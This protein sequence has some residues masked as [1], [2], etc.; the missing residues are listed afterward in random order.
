MVWPFLRQA[1]WKSGRLGGVREGWGWGGCEGE[2]R[3]NFHFRC[4]LELILWYPKLGVEYM[5]CKKGVWT[6]CVD[7]GSLITHI[8]VMTM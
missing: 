5:G 8:R 2:G 7:L 4:G 3:N 6:G 1:F